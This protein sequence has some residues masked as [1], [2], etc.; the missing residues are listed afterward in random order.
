MNFRFYT[1]HQ[2]QQ[3]VPLITLHMFC[4]LIDGIRVLKVTQFH[5]AFVIVKFWFNEGL[6]YRFDLIMAIR[7]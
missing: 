5:G 7:S 4:T 6:L 3:Y 1:E 2:L